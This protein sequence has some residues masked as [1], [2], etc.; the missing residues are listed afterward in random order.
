MKNLLD[1]FPS[2]PNTYGNA[3]ISLANNIL[4]G[5]RKRVEE[6]NASPE[7]EPLARDTSVSWYVR[8]L[9]IRD[10]IQNG[11]EELKTALGL[12]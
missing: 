9:I 6:I 1:D 8:N 7:R 5:A 12:K 11:S 10:I 4:W 2:N 3:G